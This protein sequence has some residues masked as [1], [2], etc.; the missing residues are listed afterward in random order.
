MDIEL[1]LTSYEIKEIIEDAKI[2]KLPVCECGARMTAHR[3]ISEYWGMMREYTE[4][5]CPECGCYFI[6]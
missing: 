5:T 3:E 1:H 6:R 4:Y 2:E